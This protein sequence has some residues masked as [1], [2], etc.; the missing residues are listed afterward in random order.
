MGVRP[1]KWDTQLGEVTERVYD[2]QETLSSV[3]MP[4]KVTSFISCSLAAKDSIHGAARLIGKASTIQ[5]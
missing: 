2:G 3:L 5:Y 1:E 4:S